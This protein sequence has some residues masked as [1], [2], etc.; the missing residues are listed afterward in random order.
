MLSSSLLHMCTRYQR[1]D[2][3]YRN[4]HANEPVSLL[5]TSL[6]ISWS[7]RIQ[8]SPPFSVS[9]SVSLSLS[10]PP[11]LYHFA[12]RHGRRRQGVSTGGVL[13]SQN[14]RGCRADTGHKLHQHQDKQRVT[15]QLF[16]DLRVSTHT[17]Q[18]DI[19]L[20]RCRRRKVRLPLN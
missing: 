12:G 11:S 4:R 17:C 1:P 7:P 10:L 6:A 2:V 18:R 3:S 5:L 20:C 15:V 19:P 13:W 14:E 16:G 9:V 8:P